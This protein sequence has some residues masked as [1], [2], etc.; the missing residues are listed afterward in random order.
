[1]HTRISS[2]ANPTIKRI[3]ALV[4]QR[5]ERERSGAFFV[6]GIRLVGEAIQMGAAIETLII[7]PD[8]LTSPFAQQLVAEQRASGVTWI[9]VT[10]EVFRSIS[11]KD[12]PQGIGALVRQRWEQ[13][14]DV[15]LEAPGIAI[16]Q[17]A[18]HP[19]LGG[20]VALDA[21]QDPGNL[22]AILRTCDAVGC[23]GVILLG[24]TADPYDPAA[25][26]GSMG[27]IFAQRLTR[28][29]FATFADW[30]RQHDY[31]LIGASDSASADYQSV[32]YPA[33]AVLLMGS[34]REGLSA[35]QQ[36]LCDILARIPMVGR[37]DSL[38]LAVAT[39]AMLY[40]M[41]NQRRRSM[42]RT[43]SR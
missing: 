42:P 3:R 38:N 24:H 6:E 27:A 32:V 1:M 25:L 18:E 10:A 12:G 39:G 17:G 8:L 14:E 4:R 22:G 19:P 2:P 13:L 21:V 20:W 26:R 43:S 15:R 35:E 23:T 41:F 16:R 37:G 31:P 34:E 7:A 28:A 33:P 29:T 5:K 30:K 11:Q 40:E 36:S 9:D